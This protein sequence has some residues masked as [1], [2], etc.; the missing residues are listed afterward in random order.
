V[1]PDAVER[2]LAAILSADVVGYSRLMAEDEAGTIRTLTDYREA[3]AMLVR[4][5][6]GR[7]VDS[8]GDNVLAEFPT[9]LDA[10]RA[11]VEIQRVI[12]VRNADLAQD[13]RM[14][15]RIGVHLGD[16]AVEGERVYGDGVNIAARLEGLAEAGGICISRT[17][18]EQVQ[19]KLDL[20]YQ[21][22]GEQQVKNI[23]RPVYA[24][25]VRPGAVPD[26]PVRPV[27]ARRR[28]LRTA[29]LVAA[30]VVLLVAGA[31]WLSWPRPLGPLLDLTG[32]SGPPVNPPLPDEP[33]IVVLPF[34]NMS[35]D[36]EQEYFSD[37]ITED[38]TT[39]LSRVPGLFVIARNSAFTYKGGAVPVETVGRELGVRYVL[40]G[41]VRKAGDRVRI[42]AQLI[43]ASTAFH[44]WSQRYDRDLAD[45]F[46]L[47]SEISEEILGALQVEIHEA[48][49]DRVLR[50]RTHHLGAY[51]AFM[52]A[53]SHYWRATREDNA[54]AR[55][56]A[57]RAIELDPSY[58]DAYTMISAT[59]AA[60][61]S[62]GWNLDPSLLERAE[63]LARRALDLNSSVPGGHLALGGVNLLRGRLDEAVAAAERAIELAP[64][65]DFPHFFLATALARQGR[66]LAAAQEIN[67][68]MR[69]NPRPPAFYLVAVGW[70]NLRAGREREAVEM[71]E[72]ARAANPDLIHARVALASH[73][74]EQGRHEEARAAV[75]EILRVNP[76][77]TAKQAA[78]MAVERTGSE[79][80]AEV[81]AHLRSAGLP[82]VAQA[83]DDPFTVPGFSG[84]PA[85]AV[86]PFDNLSG[87]PEQEYFADGM[88]EDLITRI[89]AWRW[90]PVIARNSSFVY[91]GQAVDVKQVS[92]ELGVRY[93]VEGSVRKG[94][95][96]VRISA[97]LID[98]TTGHHVWAES[99][100]RELRDI[101]AVQDEITDSIVMAMRP[102]L[103]RSEW[104]RAARREPRDLRAYD[105]TQ[106]G[107]WYWAKHT[108]DDNLRARSLFEQA[109]ERDPSYADAWSGLA[110]THSDDV[111]Q[112]RTSSPARSI[113]ELQRAARRSVSLDPQWARGHYALAMAQYLAGHRD[114][115]IAS[116]ESA[117]ELDP[118]LPAAYRFLG[119][120][121]A[122]AGRPD[123][124]IAKIET[125][126][127]LDPR[128]PRMW[129]NFQVAV[130]S[131]IRTTTIR[132]CF[133]RSAMR[134]W[135]GSTKP[136]RR[137]ERSCDCSRTTRWP[138]PG[139]SSLP[140]M[141]TSS[142]GSS[143][144]CARPGWRSRGLRAPSSASSFAQSKEGLARLPPGGVG[145][146]L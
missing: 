20:G 106:Q 53:L 131:T 103:R 105:L 63:E 21:D 9:A 26:E 132:M 138:A 93:V 4:Q 18:R 129:I 67:R 57:E 19:D 116:A 44:L 28:R 84:A 142:N 143:P 128:D 73:Y 77:L 8:P 102:E 123:D 47:Q 75:E 146:A 72:R 54:E 134:T 58:A 100:D 3:I 10:V 74:E 119:V 99:Y 30:A 94:G 97:Q 85:I 65:W 111:I 110:V 7:V 114:E 33:S 139:R 64:N 29:G 23:P 86:L 127:R 120:L 45:I 135:A 59:Y 1:N 49:R 24:Y 89:S 80:L 12:R 27:S 41:S 101:F 104:E 118:S 108:A 43:D 46:A 14:E 130:F 81:E 121:I 83:A 66:F 141:T 62:R 92:R 145:S 31:I 32:L 76:E 133:S 11:A 13:R 70:V 82:E 88:A 51:D 5:H 2:K 55:R 122:F 15:F 144:A 137:S 6:R 56:F 37:G 113:S 78:T 126:M 87:D 124:G 39:D 117:I 16:V 50:K 17:V 38:L 60:E 136:A 98:A 125:G 91:K 90:F 112:Q 68:A 71:W 140:P 69:L 25:R 42:T 34:A 79:Y 61:Y 48:E 36:P 22:L 109:I 35:G 52:R 115:A 96:R 95:D 107:W 40:E